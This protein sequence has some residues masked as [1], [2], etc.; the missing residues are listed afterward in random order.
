MNILYEYI[1]YEYRMMLVLP[2][3]LYVQY[4]FF[5]ISKYA[6]QR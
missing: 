5:F 1:I 3:K 4:I 6:Q 2:G